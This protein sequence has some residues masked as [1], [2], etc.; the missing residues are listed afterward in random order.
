MTSGDHDGR[1][2]R[3]TS[4]ARHEGGRGRLRYGLGAAALAVTVAAGAA[5]VSLPS[6]APAP[7]RAAT[8][9]RFTAPSPDP[10]VKCSKG[11]PTRGT[12]GTSG[13]ATASPNSSAIA[14]AADPSIVDVTATLTN[15]EAAG[16]GMI[17]TSSGEILTNNHV[18]ANAVSIT[19]KVSN[20]SQTFPATV[21]GT[22]AINDVAVL[23]ARGATGLPTV[24]AGDSTQLSV[25]QGVVA[26]GNALNRPGPPAVT[27]GAIT[28]LNR[29]VT[30]A[31]DAGATEELSNL[32][33]TDALLEPGNSGGPLFD[34]T[35]RVIGMNTAAARGRIPQSGTND[36]FAIPINDA[37][38]I[39][40]QI[41]NSHG[42]PRPNVAPP[43]FLGIS[44]ENSPGGGD[45]S[46]SSRGSGGALN[47]GRG[48]AL[49]AGVQPGSPAAG[50][51]V[52]P[53]DQILSVDGQSILSS[54]TLAQII[55]AKHAGDT[56]QVTWID[57]AGGQHRATVTLAAR[58]TP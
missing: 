52:A 21:A 29:S 46:H 37:V 31:N 36:G 33:E 25:G 32:I 26:I 58:P 35:G 12:P 4:S 20:G 10:C 55:G 44:I 50:A 57:Q 53:G 38:A 22:D 54:A 43:A 24:Q 7:S 45:S 2:I 11:A 34:A 41:E 51:G 39:V 17:L 48:G 47:N 42:S 28:A 9:V 16:T 27:E 56:V 14:A 13:P 8:S 40:H 30:V 23:Q 49:V 1:S 19:V 6:S 18:I 3:L 15:G 5:T